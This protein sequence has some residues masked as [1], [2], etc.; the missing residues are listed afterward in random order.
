MLQF[1]QWVSH[2]LYIFMGSDAHREIKKKSERRAKPKPGNRYAR[3]EVVEGAGGRG[4]GGEDGEGGEG[5]G[6]PARPGRGWR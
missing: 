2:K 5:E 1:A 6:G 3:R 4:E